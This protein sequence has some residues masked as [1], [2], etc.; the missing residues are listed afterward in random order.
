[1]FPSRSFTASGLTLKS[2]T[3]SELGL[4]CSVRESSSFFLLHVVVQGENRLLAGHQLEVSLS[5]C[6]VPGHTGLPDM[7]TE[8]ERGEFSSKADA[9]VSLTNQRNSISFA[10]LEKTLMLGKIEGRRMKG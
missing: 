3:H 4:A 7:A 5:F 8:A 10:V 6:L 2:L 1:M 9:T